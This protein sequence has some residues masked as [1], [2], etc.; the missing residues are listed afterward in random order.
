MSFQ[1]RTRTALGALGLSCAVCACS[2]GGSS[3]VSPTLASL[4][5]AP[6]VSVPLPVPSATP[7]V[8]ASPKP[9]ATPGVVA[10]PKP[11]ATPGVV[12]SATPSPPPGGYPTI[13]GCQVFPADNPW[14]T[15]IS[16]YPL[17]P[18]SANYMAEM[19]PNGTTMLT[20][21]F[22]SIGGGIPI[23][24]DSIAPANF[25]PITFNQSPTE[26]DPGPY[27][28]PSN[29]AIEADSDAH[30]LIVDQ[31]NC[32]LYETFATSYSSAAGWAA[33]SGAIFN[34]G[35]D[36]LRPEH[37][38]SADA[39]GLPIAAGLVRYAEVQ[40]GALNHAVRFT[41]NTTFAGHIHPATD[42]SGTNVAYS[43]PMGLRLRLKAGFSLA[44]FHGE[45]LVILQALKRYGMMVADNGSDFYITGEANPNW[46]VADLA[47][48]K[49][50]PA[51]ALEVVET[52][53]V[54]TP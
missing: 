49:T 7:G 34:L 31:Y 27:P 19:N 22:N 23:N 37:W 39:A 45:S 50:V 42:D 3:G 30:M 11:S 33:G 1:V 9:S 5:S 25:T 41:M 46:N 20:A 47:Q 43:P 4:S 13:G 44:G 16:N 48:M 29:P 36:A 18:N 2:G 17:N 24:V 35:S 40:A 6:P 38:A 28:I 53:P 52:G 26:S 15:D 32:Y 14:N 21:D 51:S 12:A 54:I 10:S 8:V